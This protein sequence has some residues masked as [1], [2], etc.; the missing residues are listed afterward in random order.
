MGHQKNAYWYGSKISISEA[1]AIAPHNNA[2]SMQVV[3][4]VLAGMKWVIANPKRGI[5]EPDEVNYH[6][7]LEAAKPYLGTVYGEYTDWKPKEES[8]LKIEDFL[9]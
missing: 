4:G 9:S 8:Q 7:I 1:R 3:A 5:V 6:E 2:T